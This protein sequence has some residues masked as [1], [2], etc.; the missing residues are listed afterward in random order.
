[1][2][3]ATEYD[4]VR[5]AYITMAEQARFRP[6]AP[7]DGFGGGV[8]SDQEL[9]DPDI[10]EEEASRYAR[11]FIAQEDRAQFMIGQAVPSTR[12]ALVYIIEAARCMCST[13]RANREVFARRLLKMAMDHLTCS[14]DDML[15]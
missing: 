2:S 4:R 12:T 13:Q 1:M 10:L 11:K 3:R 14:Y 9:A 8:L 6:A 5:K 15:L 7:N